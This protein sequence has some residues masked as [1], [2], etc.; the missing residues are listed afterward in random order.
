MF[1]VNL[2]RAIGYR[3]Q[4]VGERTIPSFFQGIDCDDVSHR[5]FSAHQVDAFQLILIGCLYLDFLIWDS[6]FHEFS[7]DVGEGY[8]VFVILGL[9]LEKDDRTNIVAAIRLF[10]LGFVFQVLSEGYG[11]IDY[12]YMILVV[13]HHDREFDHVFSFQACWVNK[14]DDVAL[15]AWSGCQVE[16]EARVDVGKRIDAQVTLEVMALVDN[17]DGIEMGDDL[18]E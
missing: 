16:H 2:G 18:N 17:R 11:A 4:D 6:C 8:A 3:C 10:A 15:V 1:H 9:C 7:L 5:T 14:T 13:A 12:I